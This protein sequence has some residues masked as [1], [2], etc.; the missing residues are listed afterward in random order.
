MPG[1]N[2]RLHFGRRRS[3]QAGLLPA[4]THV[5]FTRLALAIAAWTAVVTTA[6]A[7]T[8]TGRT[9]ELFTSTEIILLAVFGGA[10]S[11]A[12]MSA[13]WLIRERSRILADNDQL[14]HRISDLRASNERLDALANSTDQLIAV[15]DGPD[16][17]PAIL[18][19]LD[20]SAGVPADRRDFL[21]FG[22]WLAT[23]SAI[24]IEGALARLRGEA[25][26]FEL[27]LVTQDG[28]AL[29]AQ[30]R[31]SGHHAFVRFA[32]LSQERSA[33]PLMKTEN[34]RLRTT[35]DELQAVFDLLLH[36]VWL[37]DAAG[38]LYW[39]NGAYAHAVD[40]K[41]GSEAVARNAELLDRGQRAT[42][43]QS[44]RDNPAFRGTLPLV[45]AGDRRMFDIVEYRGTG[46]SAGIAIDRG[47]V[48]DIRATLEKTTA[49][50]AQTLDQLAT[51]I[52]MFDGRQQLR[53]YNS[54]FQKLWNLPDSF[55]A[56]KPTNAQVL[57]AIRAED[58]LPE[59]PDWRKWREQQLEIYR[60]ISAREDWWHLPDGQTLRVVANPHIQGGATWVFENV[61]ERLALE[62]NYNALMRI[63][64]ETL[65]NLNEAIAVFGLD[66]KLR[67]CNPAFVRFWNLEPALA[68][69]GTHISQ[70]AEH[71]RDQVAVIEQWNRIAEAITGFD[72]TRGDLS[73][74]LE[75]TEGD[76]YDYC[77]VRL[78]EGQTMLALTDMTAAANVERA[79]KERNDALE[80]S[81]H[82]KNRF[83]QHVSYEL[84]APLT[85][86]AGFSE[87]LAMPNIGSL[88]SKQ[89]EYVGHISQ[90][91]DVLAA[92]IDDILDLATI[93][94]GA[95]TLDIADIQLTGTVRQCANELYARFATHGIHL[96]VDIE[97]DADSIEADGQRLQQIVANLL[98]NAI[99]FSP[100]GGT[101]ALTSSRNGEFVE[102]AVSDEGPGVAEADREVIFE[103]FE[104]RTAS[105]RRKGVGLGLS[106][107]RSFAE[108]HGGSLHVE[109]ALGRGARF[110]CRLPQRNRSARSA[111]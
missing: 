44:Q 94:A 105:G 103:R 71:C 81:G 72:D 18:G 51:A 95:M 28:G 9:A 89:S 56:G 43:T 49:T 12:I 74:R 41:T 35:L 50:H 110:V 26:S 36:P 90:S 65:D 60:A 98:D 20:K 73:G 19:A 25:Q 83:I 64:G 97:A 21:A 58:R 109:P 47:D 52:A 7:Q 1:D 66:G 93:D 30:G 31:V 32:E 42:V 14:R 68:E 10:M 106:V 102:I 54:S 29:E 101:V 33:V 34:E 70:L 108:L 37:R 82:L 84:R 39:T 111:A 76:I 2:P 59:F 78:P 63:Q 62:S 79:L 85:S 15:W 107:A 67:L 45:V 38:A 80:Q 48:D 99:D 75:T 40:C 27:A 77:L 11:F 5:S 96:N 61:T 23:D 22:K 87:L 8:K 86:I 92:I 100:D 3:G 13:F 57:D 69:S 53:F 6:A 24:A 17:R 4:G 16:N 88:N 46:G 104:G 91:A 55:L